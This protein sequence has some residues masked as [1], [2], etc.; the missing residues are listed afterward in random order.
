MPNTPS[1]NSLAPTPYD[2][3]RQQEFILSSMWIYSDLQQQIHFLHKSQ[4]TYNHQQLWWMVKK[5]SMSKRFW[6][7][8]IQNKGEDHNLNTKSNGQDT[9]DLHGKELQPWPTLMH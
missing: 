8:S 1:L 5:N 4:T 6:M 9:H 7:R 3:T 2:W